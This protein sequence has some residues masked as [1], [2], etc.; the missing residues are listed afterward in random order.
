M[1]Y[2]KLELMV[3]AL[4]NEIYLG[5]PMKSKT[6]YKVMSENR[7]VFTDQVIRACAEH[8]MNLKEGEGYEFPGHG[9]LVWKPEKVSEEESA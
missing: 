6:P 2:E 9:K 1:A 3:A 7:R 4:S 5:A 8:M